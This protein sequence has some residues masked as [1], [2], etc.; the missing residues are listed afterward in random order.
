MAKRILLAFLL[1]TFHAV[2]SPV[3]DTARKELDEAIAKMGAK[4]D[5]VF[6]I[7]EDPSLGYDGVRIEPCAD[8]VILAG[9][10]DR[11]PIYAVDVYLEKYCGVRWWAP[12]ESYY[13]KLKKLPRPTKKYV[14]VPPFRIRETFYRSTLFDVD[15]K[16]RSKVNA[17]SYTRYILPPNKEQ[18]IPPEKGGNHKLVFFKARRSAY[19]SF[20]MIIPP[21]RHFAAHPE[22][23]SLV[24]GKRVGVRDNNSWSA[25]KG[26]LC[27]TNEEMFREYV[28]ET[29]RLLR[30]SPDCD[31]IQVTQNDW[32][33]D[34]CECDKCKAVYERE[35]AISGLYI[36]FANRVAAEVE[37]EFP[38]VTID[39]FAYQFT[40][41]APKTVRPRH[42]VV[43]RLCDIECAF[44]RPLTDP[45]YLK[46]RAFRKDVEGTYAQFLSPSLK[47][48]YFSPHF[49]YHSHLFI[50][51]PSLPCYNLPVSTTNALHFSGTGTAPITKNS[52]AHFRRAASRRKQPTHLLMQFQI[53]CE[54]GRHP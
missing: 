21:E 29:K 27:L 41:K 46:N 15:F 39:T 34:W 13:P 7:E 33:R 14:Y 53:F 25:C 26:Q 38:K 23:F 51:F 32:D 47:R 36:D 9:H 31:S 48:V 28:R 45:K 6:H 18:F 44:N 3:T 49:S 10:P 50:V 11:G 5:F 4:A 24:K 17:T 8:G 12:G 43:V 16:V 1:T 40:R 35:G 19:H 37:K 20:F 30:E 54:R 52:T 2:A 22:W 42:N